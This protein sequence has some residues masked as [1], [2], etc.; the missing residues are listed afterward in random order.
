MIYDHAI[1]HMRIDWSMDLDVC[2]DS[3]LEREM[4]KTDLE[5]C[6]QFLESIEYDLGQCIYRDGKNVTKQITD[7]SPKET[8]ELAQAVYAVF[9]ED[10]KEGTLQ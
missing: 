2:T 10:E 9:Y 1:H 6:I 5:N 7:L 8:I 3:R 4:R